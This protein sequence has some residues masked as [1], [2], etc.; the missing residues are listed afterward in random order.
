MN[1]YIGQF[2]QKKYMNRLSSVTKQQIPCVGLKFHVS[3]V[4]TYMTG[5]SYHPT[6]L[7]CWHP[8]H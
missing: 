3:V 8:E 5:Y 1:K 6:L 2:L 7:W 4:A